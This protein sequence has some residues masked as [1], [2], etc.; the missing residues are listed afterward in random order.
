MTGKLCKD[1]EQAI[2]DVMLDSLANDD[3]VALLNR[4]R[5]HASPLL[6]LSIPFH[7]LLRVSIEM[8]TSPIATNLIC[9]RRTSLFVFCVLLKNNP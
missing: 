5:P 4:E 3:L 6:T 7:G 2:C 1:D 8:N 9:S